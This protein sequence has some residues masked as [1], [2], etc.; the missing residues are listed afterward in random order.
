MV[1]HVGISV[2]PSFSAPPDAEHRW[3]VA[4]YPAA[5]NMFFL[6]FITIPFLVILLLF[7]VADVTANHMY[8]SFKALDA[9]LD[10]AGA[11]FTGG[12]HDP[13]TIRVFQKTGEEI[14]ALYWQANLQSRNV[15]IS[16]LCVSVVQLVVRPRRTFPSQTNLIHDRR[17]SISQPRSISQI[18]SKIVYPQ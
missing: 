16:W 18:S 7:G 12:V 14:S 8:W 3:D 5:V 1:P 2:A 17:S 13:S 6:T 15:W 9:E 11:A 10:A 4:N